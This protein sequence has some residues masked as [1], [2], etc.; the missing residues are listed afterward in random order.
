[1]HGTG[2]DDRQPA[3]GGEGGE[4]V[5]VH[6]VERSAVVEE[7]DGDAGCSEAVDERVELGARRGDVRPRRPRAGDGIRPGGI[8]RRIAALQRRP[9]GTLAAPGEDHPVVAARGVAAAARVLGE[10]VEVVD[11]SALLAAR[12]LR[13]GDGGGEAVVAGLAAC[14]DEQVGALGVGHALLRARE[15]ERQL[16]A[17]HRREAVRFSGLGQAHN[18]VEAVVVGQRE[19]AEPEP[20]GLLQQ[21]FG[22]RG[23]VEEAEGGVRVQFGVGHDRGGIGLFDAGSTVGRPLGRPRGGVAPVGAGGRC[24]AGPIA[25]AQ[26]ALELAPRDRRVVPARHQGTLGGVRAVH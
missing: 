14:E 25:V 1:M 19:P 20:C 11:R 3:L 6:G 9:H 4:H 22:A 2:R 21:F 23:A 16:G 7:L 8:A 5:V 10:R 15:P 24:G 26:A 13:L 18:T 12:E 17:E